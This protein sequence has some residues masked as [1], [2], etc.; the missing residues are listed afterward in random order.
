MT[1][2]IV[3]VI[4]NGKEFLFVQR[5][6]FKKTLP[7][8]WAFPSGTREEHEEIYDTA[9]RESVEELGIEIIPETVL[10]TK[11]LPEFGAKLHFVICSISSGEP[12]IK[13]PEEIDTII[14]STFTD[15]FNKFNDSQIGHGLIHLRK[16]PQIWQ[17]YS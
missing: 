1:D 9:K 12:S 14:W 2:H 7:S 5:S 16:N 3:L 6:K 10:C 8:A 11:E 17:E 4:R 13:Q 15:F